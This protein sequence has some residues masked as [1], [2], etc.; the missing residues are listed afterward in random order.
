MGT[1]QI[2]PMLSPA[3]GAGRLRHQEGKLRAVLRKPQSFPRIAEA[4]VFHAIEK[5]PEEDRRSESPVPEYIPRT[6]QL[7][8][9]APC[10]CFRMGVHGKDSIPR[11]GSPPLYR[12]SRRSVKPTGR[13]RPVRSI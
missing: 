13:S 4:Y 3:I 11:G 5:D 7:S 6:F 12:I 1:G 10:P 8:E 9:Q 2:P